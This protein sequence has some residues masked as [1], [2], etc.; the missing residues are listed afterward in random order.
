MRAGASAGA[1]RLER[2][3][4]VRTLR[5][6]DPA[7]P[8]LCAGWTVHDLAAHVVQREGRPVRGAVDIFSPAGRDVFLPRFAA[9]RSYGELVDAVAAGPPA[10]S[11]VGWLGD[12]GNLLELVVHHEDVRRGQGHA[13]AREPAH[14]VLERLWALLPATARLAYRRAGTGVV[15]VVPGGPRRVVRRGADAVAVVGSPVELALHAAGR[16]TAADVRL[17]GEP[18]TVER[19]RAALG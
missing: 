15:L 9:H 14:E 13:P 18:R 10:W 2:A 8:T 5:A 6:A 16:R 11:P 17:L 19:F 1:S 12:A 3:D 7:A 4:L